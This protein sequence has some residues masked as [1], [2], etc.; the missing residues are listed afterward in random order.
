MLWCMLPSTPINLGA[1]MV[2][3]LCRLFAQAG[4]V[5]MDE[6][7]MQGDYLIDIPTL[8]KKHFLESSKPP[9][10]FKQSK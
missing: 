10:W 5:K 3:N 9:H 6:E 1:N 7:L 4:G 8:T 2:V